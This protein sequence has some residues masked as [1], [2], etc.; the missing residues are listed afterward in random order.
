MASFTRVC[1][2]RPDA[3]SSART[4][5]SKRMVVGTLVGAFCIPRRRAA[6]FSRNSGKEWLTTAF[7]R[8]ASS[9]GVGGRSSPG[10]SAI[11]FSHASWLFGKF[12]GKVADFMFFSLT[13][14]NDVQIIAALRVSQMHNDTIEKAKQ[15]NAQFA[16]G[17]PVIVPH[18]YWAIKNR[19][20]PHKIQAV[21]ADVALPFVFVP[22]NHRQNALTA[23][24]YVKQIVGRSRY[25]GE[26]FPTNL[27]Y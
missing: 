5:A 19:I 2:P 10:A 27:I 12:L 21:F 13:Q 3:F 20:A 7:F 22:S 25:R 15:I 26:I 4:S 11:S 1:Q 23:A 18:D 6:R 9:S 16:I 14:A 8:R 17:I 24:Q